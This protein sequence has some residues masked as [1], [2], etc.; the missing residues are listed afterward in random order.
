MSKLKIRRII[1]L[2]RQRT[3][4]RVSEIRAAA[5]EAELPSMADWI[6]SRVVR[7]GGELPGPTLAKRAKELGEQRAPADSDRADEPWW[8]YEAQ[9]HALSAKKAGVVWD[10]PCGACLR[11]RRFAE[12]KGLKAA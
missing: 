6:P 3:I 1:D 10:C 2:P 11:V 8:F 4:A 9:H 5:S 7:I 12:E